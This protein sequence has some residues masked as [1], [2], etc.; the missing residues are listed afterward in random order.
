MN[1]ED[2]KAEGEH[3]VCYGGCH[4]VSDKPGVCQTEGCAHKGH[5]LEK[6]DCADGKHNDFVRP[7]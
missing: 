3:Y 1:Q 7:E 4:G 5:A 6:C 2:T